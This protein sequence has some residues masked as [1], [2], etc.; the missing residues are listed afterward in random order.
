MGACF[1]RQ[2]SPDDG[3]ITFYFVD[4]FVDQAKVDEL[5]A[6]VEDEVRLERMAEEEHSRRMEGFAQ[7]LRALHGKTSTV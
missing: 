2:S 4:E 3:I 5:L 1:S 6:M 7:R